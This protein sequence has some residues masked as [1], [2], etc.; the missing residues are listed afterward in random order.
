MLLLGLSN[1]WKKPFSDLLLWESYSE[2]MTLFALSYCFILNSQC[3]MNS[4]DFVSFTS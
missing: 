4:L 2:G 1:L 3:R